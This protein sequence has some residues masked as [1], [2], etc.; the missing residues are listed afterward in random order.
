[1]GGA[2]LAAPVWVVVVVGADLLA[3]FDPQPTRTRPKATAVIATPLI[4][5]VFFIKF[6]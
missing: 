6:S 2:A 4:A 5:V 3:L 1:V